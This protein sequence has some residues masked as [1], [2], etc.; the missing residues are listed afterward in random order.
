MVKLNHGSRQPRR[1]TLT[2]LIDVV[3]ILLVF[4]MLET[5]FREEGGMQLLNAEGGNAGGAQQ[6]IV[7][8]LFDRQSLWV[9][10]RKMAYE[11]WIRTH[12]AIDAAAE[13]RTAPGIPVQHVVDVVDTL[14]ERGAVRVR[15]A[16]VQGFGG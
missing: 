2:P 3:F 16:Q 4:F 6:T 5:T 14:K 15:L 8:E 10:G 13:V 1:I 9:D 7:I 11:A 12:K